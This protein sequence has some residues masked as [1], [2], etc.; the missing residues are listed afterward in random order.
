M[1]KEK[2]LIMRSEATGPGVQQEGFDVD[3]KIS[4][5]FCRVQLLNDYFY[6]KKY[7][8]QFAT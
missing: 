1:I 2:A 4:V 3:E 5:L 8:F 6:T 7:N